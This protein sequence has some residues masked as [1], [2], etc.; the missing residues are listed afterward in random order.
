MESNKIYIHTNAS[1][2][3]GQREIETQGDINIYATHYQLGL[4]VPVCLPACLCPCACLPVP[5]LAGCLANMIYDRCCW[6]ILHL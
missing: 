3:Y 6:P 1:S 5:S 4:C 2:L